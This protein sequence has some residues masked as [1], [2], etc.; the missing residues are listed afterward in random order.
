MTNGTGKDPEDFFIRYRA[1]E[2]FNDRTNS[3]LCLIRKPR[4]LN[5][6]E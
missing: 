5:K 3:I 1:R 2:K 6:Y 4:A